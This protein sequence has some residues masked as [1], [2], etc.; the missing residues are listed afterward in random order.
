MLVNAPDY[1]TISIRRY[2][3]AAHE[4]GVLCQLGQELM[5]VVTELPTG[6]SCMSTL[7]IEDKLPPQLTCNQI[8]FRVIQIFHL[9]ILKVILNL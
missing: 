3:G 2:H 5:A 9:L 4:Y 6:N 7:F 8:F 1:R